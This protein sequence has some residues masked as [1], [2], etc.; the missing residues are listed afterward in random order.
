M[1]IYGTEGRIE[2]EIPFNAP[3]DRPCKVWHQR[4]SEEPELFELETA[5]Q[6]TLQGDLFSKAVLEDTDVPT[7]I[8]NAVAN[9]RV[10]EAIFAS[11]EE[12]RW[13]DCCE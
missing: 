2:I 3:W 5:N 4:G 11:A 13:V 12:G 6:Y 9:M 8:E 10:I 1:N 7:P